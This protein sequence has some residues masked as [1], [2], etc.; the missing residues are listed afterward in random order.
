[1]IDNYLG[2]YIT[3]FLIG[4]FVF[5]LTMQVLDGISTYKALTKVGNFEQ[6]PLLA[7]LFKKI[8]LLPGLL[9]CKYAIL[10]ATLI[11]LTFLSNDWRIGLAI[12]T[13]VMSII[14][15]PAVIKNFRIS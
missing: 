7:A 14:Y 3:F 2:S 13:D 11:G 5:L 12:G 1:M 10:Q 4:S 15:I 9:L 8:G 6:N